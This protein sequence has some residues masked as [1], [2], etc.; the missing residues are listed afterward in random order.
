MMNCYE[1]LKA[2]NFDYFEE[3]EDRKAKRAA[4]ERKIAFAKM[5]KL[6]LTMEEGVGIDVS[7][8]LY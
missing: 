4:L 3:L 5:E 8:I 7:A 6:L 1:E 2:K